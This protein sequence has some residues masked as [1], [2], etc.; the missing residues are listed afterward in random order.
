MDS[1][2]NAT[3]E[4]LNMDDLAYAALGFAFMCMAIAMLLAWFFTR[5]GDK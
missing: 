2:E 3:Q 4:G 1:S 5:W